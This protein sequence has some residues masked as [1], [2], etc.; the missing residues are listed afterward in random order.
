VKAALAIVASMPLA[1]LAA[2]AIPTFDSLG[3]YWTPSAPPG[4]TGCE[5]R[6][7]KAAESA[8]KQG[9]N[10]WYDPRNGECRGSLVQLAPGTQYE[11]QLG[12][13]GGPPAAQ[14]TATTW[15]QNFPIAKT[16]QV[17]SGSGPLNITE[18]GTPSGY[19]LYTGPA[20]LD[21]AGTADYNIQ[22]SAPY[23]IV[24]G[25]ALKGARIDAIRL[26]PGAHDVVIE[27]N[28]ISGWGRFRAQIAPGWAGGVE[29]DSAIRARCDAGPWL[30][31]LIVQH[32]RLHHPRYGANSWDFGAPRGP[33]A[34]RLEHCGGNH[35]IRYNAIYSSENHYFRDGIGGASADS[36]IYGNHISHAWNDAI[37]AAGD[38][39][40]LRIWGNYT[41]QTAS[42]VAT[43]PTHLGPVYVFRNVMNRSR[44][45]SRR[46]PDEDFDAGRA[47]A[48]SGSVWSFGGGRRYVFHNTLLQAPPPAGSIYESGAG[49]ALGGTAIL[50]LVNTVSRNN[51]YQIRK[52]WLAAIHEGPG[53]ESA[54]D[55]DYDLVN[56]KV[57]AYPAAEMNGIAGSPVYAAGH[58]WSSEALGRYQLAP[59]SPGYDGGERLPNFNDGF[60]GAAPD[61][62][63]H[64]AGTPPMRFGAAAPA[65]VWFAGMETGDLSEW[66][67][68]TNSG[69]ADSLAVTAAAAGIAAKNGN[70]VMRQSVTGPD[71]GTRM[72]RFPE[73]DA[74][75]KAGTP[76]HVSW[77][78]YFPALPAIDPAGFFSL[79]QIASRDAAGGD[80][81]IWSLNLHPS[82][83]TLILVWSANR[84][85][86][87]EG[88]HAGESGSR[89]YSSSRLAPVGQW[90]FFEVMITPAADFSGAVK[91]W[92]NGELLFDQS[93]VKTR[94]PDEGSGGFMW[95]T[96]MAY[97]SGL[98][99]TPYHHY[100]DDVALSLGRMPYTP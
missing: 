88:P 60:T 85:A 41:D 15:A 12:M 4:A 9:L 5:V 79:F 7:R 34:I 55:L 23:V 67:D 42:A 22:I 40:N 2:S 78:G 68:E 80:H 39:R 84:M 82:D 50:P 37:A 51:I 99:P 53:A 44:L 26:L 31:R 8:W 18:G 30:E 75:T 59:S 61:I 76:F 94:F 70:W 96:L 93:L 43:A 28:D 89:V 71:S 52:P 32:N 11:V 47:F 38:N 81:P 63:A 48:K 90:I 58:G 74:L 66:D 100:V 73:V 86:P 62:G 17:E 87:S 69:S 36:D 16:V 54:N 72:A 91:V 95:F 10:L 20:Q 29:G 46:A 3:L 13:P 77:W 21:V 1:A 45:L 98:M 33:H 57:F 35:V 92:M 24:R 49:F 6:Y 19:V 65:I 64:E 56:G 83:S 25:L 14:L 27:H 97:G